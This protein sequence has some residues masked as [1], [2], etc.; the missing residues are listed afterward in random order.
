MSLKI[1]SI[2]KS[3]DFTKIN[4]IAKKFIVANFIVLTAPTPNIYF[5]DSL[6]NKVDTKSN[7]NIHKDSLESFIE[8]QSQNSTQILSESSQINDKKIKNNRKTQQ[9]FIDNFCRVGFTVSKSVSKLATQR[10]LV[11]RQLRK[12]ISENIELLCNHQDYIII[13]RSNIIKAKYSQ[14]MRDLAFALKRLKN[15]LNNSSYNERKNKTK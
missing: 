11:K 12:A 9:F 1:L 13:A 6:K 8:K 4:K 10:N 7:Q 2:K 15:D 3:S 5:K 14:I